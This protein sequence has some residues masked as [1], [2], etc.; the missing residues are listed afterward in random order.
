MHRYCKCGASM[1][2]NGLRR[3]VAVE[4]V[5]RWAAE[6]WRPV[7]GRIRVRRGHGRCTAEVCWRAGR[8]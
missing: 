8:K 1:D 4:M 3:E 2:P 7:M 5:K 6:H